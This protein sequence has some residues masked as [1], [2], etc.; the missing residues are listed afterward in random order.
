MTNDKKTCSANKKLPL[1]GFWK[2]ELFL[3][4]PLILQ[5]CDGVLTFKDT[6]Q[7]SFDN[8]GDGDDSDGGDGGDGGDI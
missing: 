7:L 8:D 3:L 5:I 2:L 1:F 6:R 4:F